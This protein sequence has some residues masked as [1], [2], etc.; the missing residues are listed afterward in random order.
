MIFMNEII[1]LLQKESD[2]SKF[3]DEL[4]KY[5]SPKIFSLDYE[6]HIYLENNHIYNEIADNSLSEN[7][8]KQ[9]DDFTL[10]FIQN[11]IPQKFQKE[12]SVNNIF[13]P[14]LIEHELFFYLLP[15]FSITVILK[16]III[17]EKPSK[18]IDF[19]EFSRFTETL[20]ENKNNVIKFPPI[21]K[22]SFYHEDL[23]HRASYPTKAQVSL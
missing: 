17:K 9:I 19:T 23:L 6:S 21:E 8:L 22:K 20:M 10:Y 15:I 4:K 2:H 5:T 13:L 18:I 11:W 16:K 14:N 3:Q 12:F 1:F 7:D